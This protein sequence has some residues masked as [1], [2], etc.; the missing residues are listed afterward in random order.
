MHSPL[1]IGL[2]VCVYVAGLFAVALWGERTKR[3]PGILMR[4][5]VIYALSLVVYCT[6]WTFYGSVGKAA[7]S[8]PLFLTIYL[9]PTLGIV[10]F[11]VLL[12]KLV[13]AKMRHRITSIADFVS[14]RY[15][16][17]QLLAATATIIALVGTVPYIA[18]QLKAVISSFHLITTG[19]MGVNHSWLCEHIGPVMVLVLAAFTILFGVRRLDPTERHQG[20]MLALVVECM[21]KL[22]AFMA[23]GIYVTYF[24]FDGMG[25]IF[26]KADS[27][28]IAAAAQT[29]NYIPPFT[30][31]AT[32][33]LLAMS[34][35]FFL[36]RQFHVSVVESSDENHIKTASWVAPLY[37]LLINLFV[38]PIAL[39]GLLL[40]HPAATADTFVLMLPL[41]FNQGWLSLLAFI[42]GFSAA[43]GM[44]VI[45]AMTMSTMVTNHLLLPL[46][47]HVRPLLGLRRHLL[48]C[49][50]AVVVLFLGAGY[51]FT[52]T[53]G[54][55]YMLVNMG[56]LSFAA[57]LQFAPAIVGG[58]FWRKGNKAGAFAGMTAGFGMWIYTLLVPALVKSDWLPHS[59]METGP[60]GLSVLHPEALFGLAGLDS[61]SHAVFW[62]LGVNITAYV[63][64]S[65]V[66]R[67][68][69]SEEELRREFIEILDTVT[70]GA[71]PAVTCDAIIRLDG[72]TDILIELFGEYFT[73]EKAQQATQWSIESA[74][75]QD[76]ESITVLQLGDLTKAAENRLSGSIGSAAAFHAIQQSGLFTKEEKE[77][78]SQ[79]YADILA[80][81]R[82]SPDELR[83]RVSAYQ[84]RE[85]LLR[86]HAEELEELVESR[87]SELRTTNSSLT[88][89]IEE[90]Q[91]AQ[92]ETE[93]LHA[94]L[95]N[96]SRKA[97][98]A[99]VA[100]NVLHNVGNILNSVNVSSSVLMETIRSLRTD[101]LGR[102]AGMMRDNAE[103]LPVFLT[104]D[105]RGRLV[106]EYI[107]KLSDNLGEDREKL[108]GEMSRLSDSIDHINEV[109]R[110]QQDNA[111]I[112]GNLT[113]NASLEEILND[114]VR[115][116]CP[117]TGQRPFEVRTDFEEELTAIVDKHKLLQILVNVIR[118]AKHSVM[119]AHPSGGGAIDIRTSAR[120][121][122]ILIE[123]QDDGVGIPEENLDLVFQHGFTTRDDG[124]G[125]G[126]HGSANTAK[127]LHG[128]IEVQSGGSGLG[129][130]FTI[131]IPREPAMAEA[132]K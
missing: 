78:L 80:Q 114:A 131:R 38:I 83:R 87:T 61:L 100:S 118:N 24:L 63:L 102:L 55:S 54:D 60:F 7:T 129:A 16:K 15:D 73:S 41:E 81:L 72:K 48:R 5:G 97:G 20:M 37:L 70:G 111:T 43:M 99:E 39:A 76:R 128:G 105:E 12:R 94:K 32:Y 26:Q 91:K 11:W 10:F 86:E 14:S 13:R 82:V 9:G 101:Q 93:R 130:T 42:G 46:I 49:R 44:V 106:P 127:E 110:V 112:S 68:T 56:M 124:H 98:M 96:T 23:V 92:Q 120:G 77:L 85:A 59:I 57:I 62:T 67:T 107:L 50:W 89:E 108:L 8:G 18:L 22:I 132:C 65:L 117:T 103:Q 2:I 35:F 126:L 125:F 74:Q 45:C 84:D 40:G 66:I 71:S 95:L 104:E 30:T 1:T 21:V 123:I 4:S 34:A 116:A 3:K 90:R 47:E 28:A 79:A 64:G 122:D 27:G 33:T 52:T 31:W 109:V 53:V 58:M 119:E 17:S 51:G 88:S 69:R 25:D 6:S 19:G 113:E 115:V 29:M 75:L 36:P 121:D